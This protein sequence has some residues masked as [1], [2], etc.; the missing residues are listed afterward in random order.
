MADLASVFVVKV[1]VFWLF[2][3]CYLDGVRPLLNK[4]FTYLLN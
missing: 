1:I 4:I 2:S 3:A